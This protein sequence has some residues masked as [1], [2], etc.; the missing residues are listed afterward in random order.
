MMEK[1]E[2]RQYPVM[3][4]EARSDE[5][6][7]RVITGYAARFGERSKLLYGFVEVIAKGAF[8]EALQT[9]NVRACW[10]HNWDHVLGSTKSGTLRL[11]EDDIGLRFALEMPDT[12][13]GRD[14]YESIRRGDVD[15]MS[16]R[17]YARKEQWDESQDPPVRTLLQVDI[18]EIS[19]TPIPAYNSTS[20]HVRS[21]ADVWEARC[22]DNESAEAAK[23]AEAARKLEMRR[24]RL[25]LLEKE[26]V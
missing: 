16:F 13:M 3:E 1:M 21:M 23:R 6:G 7:K 26:I 15:G 18:S 22:L 25:K 5:D 12:T 8:A 2:T 20:V 11:W 10:N 14:A 4:L 24:R 19:P 17:F 9:Q